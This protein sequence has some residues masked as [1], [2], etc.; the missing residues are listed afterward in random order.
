[1]F[2]PQQLKLSRQVMPGV[3]SI[4]LP[5]PGDKPGPVNVYLFKGGDNITLLDAGTSK[6][7][8][9]L[10][11]ALAEHGLTGDDL[12]RIVLTHSHIDHYG[13]VR[14]ILRSASSPIDVAGNFLKTKS[15]ATG[16]GVSRK[17]M[18]AFL[19]LMGVP[20]V[21]RNSMRVLSTA[22]TLLGEKCRVT[23]FLAEGRVIPMGDYVCRVIET[24]GHTV[25]SICL[26]A[27]RENV[28]FSGDHILP[29]IT[30]N[31]FVM[32]EEGQPLPSRLSQK[33][34]YASVDKINRLAP[35]TVFPAH[36][37]AIEDLPA[38]TRMYTDN[39]RQRE[40][41]IVDIIAAGQTV[42]YKIARKLF[43]NLN[44]ARL[45]LEIFLAVS[46]VYTHVQM[47]EYKQKVS[48]RVENERL[49]ITPSG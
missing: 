23:T 21:V 31:A 47:L 6:A 45:P 3:F 14:K 43:P 10:K 44:T 11:A 30:P 2:Q 24:P 7:F 25:D 42:V 27:E 26:Y 40:A 37:R 39:F 33:E 4:T 38:I 1:M 46:E 35:R 13:A 15:I 34:F 36:G 28:L 12:D 16:L 8:G 32:L 49:I 9:V 41:L 29:H 20:V 22:F 5:L 48:T 19:S 18:N 17:T